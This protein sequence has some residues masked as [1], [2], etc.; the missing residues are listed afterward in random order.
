[1]KHPPT[2]L[3][4]LMPNRHRRAA[5]VGAG[6]ALFTLSPAGSALGQHIYLDADGDGVHSASDVLH[7][8]GTTT[9]DVWLRTDE[10]ADGSAAVCPAGGELTISSYELILHAS[11]GTVAW[12][13][14][15]NR[16]SDFLT[17]LGSASNAT[18][19]YFGFTGVLHPPGLYRLATVEVSIQSG[20]PSIRFAS[21]TPLAGVYLTS[22]VSGCPGYDGD[23]TLKLGSDWS[24]GEGLPFP[25]P[26]ETP[27]LSPPQDVTLREGEVVEQELK[28]TDG[29]GQALTFSKGSGPP[30]LS[31]VT[32][33][34]GSG[35][36]T[37]TLRLAPGYASAGSATGVILVDDG[38]VADSKRVSITVEDVTRPTLLP[39]SDMTLPAYTAAKQTVSALNPDGVR[40][41]FTKSAGPDFL[42]VRSTGLSTAEVVVEPGPDDD[43]S[44]VGEITVSDGVSRDA[45]LFAI[46][47]TPL[48]TCGPGLCVASRIFP[49]QEE[50]RGLAIGDMNADGVPDVIVTSFLGGF[51]AEFLGKGNGT[52]Q[53]PVDIPVGE[54]AGWPYIADLNGDGYLDVVVTTLSAL[55][56][57]HYRLTI[58]LGSADGTLRP[59]SF[60]NLMSFTD[61]PLWP[62]PLRIGDVNGD[63]IPDIVMLVSA[64][65]PV[66][67]FFGN[68][69]GTFWFGGEV[70]LGF[71]GRGLAL[72][73]LNGDS[74]LD[75][76]VG[77][78]DTTQLPTP[79]KAVVRLGQGGGVFGP[80][81]SYDVNVVP[82]SLALADL[83]RDGIL[84]LVVANARLDGG[85]SISLGVG[86]GS[87]G[88]PHRIDSRSSTLFAVSDLSGDGKLDLA[89]FGYGHPA[90]V[91]LLP[92][93]GDGSFGEPHEV[94]V[95]V[96]ASDITAGDLNRD[97]RED[98]VLAQFLPGGM[99][100]VLNRGFRPA[101]PAPP[102]TAR[103]FLLGA[104]RTIPLVDAAGPSTCFQVQPE[105]GAYRNEDVDPSSFVL[106][107]DGL[108]S[109][110]SI[111]ATS[112][113]SVLADRDGDGVSEFAACFSRADLR[114]LLAG[115]RGR[116]TVEVALEGRLF[117]GSRFQAPLTLTVVSTGDP[118]PAEMAS[119]APGFSVTL[120]RGRLSE[121]PTLSVK[122][123]QD[124]FLKAKIFDVQGRLVAEPANE[125]SVARGQHAYRVG[126]GS[127]SMASGLYFYTVETLEGTVRGRFVIVR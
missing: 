101:E 90:V 61:R 110:D 107:A 6:I 79:H 19:L 103:A 76:V 84:D 29:D 15:T 33:N 93:E 53:E 34:P 120:L 82:G 117:N 126:R 88:P 98:L 116:S 75:I 38:I 1:M 109:V 14:V 31:V 46:T 124:G 104:Q 108:G 20:T 56:N 96:F 9:F 44:T 40:L 63:G 73:D 42:S 28:A 41:E 12:G 36:A 22:F 8:T 122:T 18:D 64:V 37:G 2:L 55:P 97:G 65:R 11:G 10:N 24:D 119:Q 4:L 48:P 118:S 87:F 115:V 26:N 35:T 5:L 85:V 58:L 99:T 71:E 112:T 123:T 51:I 125:S 69:D 39:L 3:L 83:N 127:G 47:V 92:G 67:L 80:A 68:G 78:S 62:D 50:P 106:H 21:T 49:V 72:G 77:W 74:I 95:N 113:K 66:A 25:A 59:Y 13:A 105:N 91:T 94:E 52:F 7:P 111:A 81:S 102:L 86:D 57:I 27:A 30:Y 43:G 89:L 60:Y 70:E 17:N 16:I 54:G 23:Y 114:K 45:E 100:V 121:Q 32:T